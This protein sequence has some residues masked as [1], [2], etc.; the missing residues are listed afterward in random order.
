MD[1]IWSARVDEAVLRQIGLLARKLGTSKKAVIERA[2]T[3]LAAGLDQDGL[4]PLQ[5][6]CGAWQRDEAAEETVDVARRAFRDDM[7]RHHR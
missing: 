6:S 4:D 2:V 1:K 3:E 5:L 7:E